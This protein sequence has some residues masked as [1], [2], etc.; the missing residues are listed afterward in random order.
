MHS[1]PLYV[2]TSYLFLGHVEIVKYLIENVADVMA[3]TREGFTSLYVAIENGHKNVVNVI[4]DYLKN[5]V[6]LERALLSAAQAGDFDR[7]NYSV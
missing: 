7:I 3:K 4:L 6:E 2:I 1:A 5:K